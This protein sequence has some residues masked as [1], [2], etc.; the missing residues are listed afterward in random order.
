VG[1][2]LAG[3][4]W[5]HRHRPELSWRSRRHR[6][7]LFFPNSSFS[8]KGGLVARRASRALSSLPLQIMVIV[9]SL[10][11]K[12]LAAQVAAKVGIT[13]RG[14][15]AAIASGACA[16]LRR[17]SSCE[18]IT[19]GA[20][21]W[22][23]PPRLVAPRQPRIEDM[24]CS[25]DRHGSRLG[26]HFFAVGSKL[27]GRRGLPLASAATRSPAA[28]GLLGATL[29]QYDDGQSG[30][31]GVAGDLAPRA[32]DKVQPAERCGCGR[33]RHPACNQAGQPN[34]AAGVLRNRG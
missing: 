8:T 21:L 9:A 6:R 22:M 28:R 34:A 13:M 3:A 4:R 7:V 20:I 19:T 16:A 33:W 17:A 11:K 15:F 27:A 2:T 23:T 5:Y 25:S 32:A 10:A 31:S 18:S 12:P 26:V 30:R 29:C 14:A 1:E 24:R